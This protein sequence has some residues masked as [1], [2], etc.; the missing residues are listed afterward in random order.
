MAL[1]FKE[2]INDGKTSAT[3]YSFDRA[4]LESLLKDAYNS[5]YD[6]GYDDGFHTGYGRGYEDSEDGY[7]YDPPPGKFA[8]PARVEPKYLNR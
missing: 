1:A 2:F 6:R 3:L 7:E 4:C 8:F 5:G